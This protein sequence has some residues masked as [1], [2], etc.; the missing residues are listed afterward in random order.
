MVGDIEETHFYIGLG[1]IRSEGRI[2]TRCCKDPVRCTTCWDVSKLFDTL[3]R[4]FV[5]RLQTAG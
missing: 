5:V 1:E 2:A 4:P 3:P